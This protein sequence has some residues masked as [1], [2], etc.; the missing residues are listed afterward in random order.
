MPSNSKNTFCPFADTGNRK[1]LRYH[2]MPVER[3]AMSFLNAS[4]S[5]HAYGSVTDFQD[6]SSYV[7]VVASFTSVVNTFQLLLK[8][9]FVRGVCACNRVVPNNE[10][11]IKGK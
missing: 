11:K 8:L 9:Y 3:F 4:S 6:A 5:F 10:H 2:A 1:C 7:E